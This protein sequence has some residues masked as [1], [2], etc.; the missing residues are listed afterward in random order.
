M[1]NQPIRQSTDTA[2][3]VSDPV[4]EFCYELAFAFR[5]ILNLIEEIFD[6]ETTDD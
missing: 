1:T 5:R 4:D 6:D 2:T 3:H